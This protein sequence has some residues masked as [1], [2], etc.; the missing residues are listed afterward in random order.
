MGPAPDRRV[1]RARGDRDDLPAAPGA[2]HR[3][4]R[5]LAGE[6]D[7]S[8]VGVE[9][10]APLRLVEFEERRVRVEA[11]VGDADIGR[12]EPGL[13]RRQQR[14]DGPSIAHIRR[15]G[16]AADALFCERTGRVLRPF[17]RAVVQ[18]DARPGASECLRDREAEA[19][20]PARDEDD[21]PGES[22]ICHAALPSVVSGAAPRRPR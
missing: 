22:A 1:R 12:A 11:R 4:R 6:E 17:E 2:D 5:R 19:G 9:D 15:E 21:L 13:D 20:R 3:A 18:G 10:G 8:Q 16:G 7:A 14:R